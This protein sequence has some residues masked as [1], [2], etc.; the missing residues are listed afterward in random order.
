M[1]KG[2]RMTNISYHERA[3]KV[4]VEIEIDLEDILSL[5][6]AHQILDFISAKELLEVMENDDILEYCR[7]VELT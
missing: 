2:A 6:P 5:V 7:M 3:K 4:Q 1:E